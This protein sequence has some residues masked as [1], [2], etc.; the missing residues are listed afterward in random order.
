MALTDASCKNAKPKD[1]S[2]KLADANGLYL[3][4]KP[5]GGR[6]WRLK[7]RVDGKE[8][9]LSFGVYP[10]V[11]L[12]EARHERDK[13]RKL[14]RKDTDP[15]QAK[16]EEKR[17]S[18][19]NTQNNFEAIAREWHE[20]KKESWTEQYGINVLR[21]LEMD[22]FPILGKRP[23]ADIEPPEML[24]AIR[25]IERRGALD[26]SKR[27]A[28]VCGQVFR[29]GIATGR[30]KRNPIPD[31]KDAFKPTI[32]GHFAA[33]DADGIPAFVRALD[34]N[35]ARLFPVT[36]IA[37]R[38]MMLT[39]VRTSNLINAEWDQFDLEKTI[40][41]IPAAN[42]KQRMA[43][44]LNPK[45]SHVVPLCT[46]AIELLIELRTYSVGKLLFPGRADHKKPMS[47]NTILG[48][49]KRM[50]YQGVMTGHG[51]RALAMSTLKEKLGYRHEVVDRQLAHAHK[52]AVDAAYDRA[53]FLDERKIMMQVWADYLDAAGSGKVIAGNFG[54]AA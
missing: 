3:L 7:Y 35:D 5:N 42:M 9:L 32:K 29:Y 2:Y 52:S 33:I 12:S 18:I 4:V 15:A 30:V 14:L 24:D 45:N 26:V 54:K 20:N 27:I 44:K 1:K 8:K 51:F 40:W 31:I 34:R 43:A 22:I 41:I 25:E 38:L 13:A 19:L 11:P 10:E 21:R 49:L 50:G 6:Y 48:A 17:L 46:Q 47:N 53:K 36:R 23:I 28:Q 37:I 39:F 16:R